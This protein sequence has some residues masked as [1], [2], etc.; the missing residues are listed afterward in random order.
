MYGNPD[1]TCEQMLCSSFSQG[2]RE[3]DLHKGTKL[4]IGRSGIH[5]QVL[6]P[7][8]S[9]LSTLCTAQLHFHG[10]PPLL[11][12]GAPRP[13]LAVLPQVVYHS[14]SG[15]TPVCSHRHLPKFKSL[16]K[17]RPAN[18]FQCFQIRN[19]LFGKVFKVWTAWPL[20]P[21][22]V[23]NGISVHQTGF[24]SFIISTLTHIRPPS[25]PLST[26]LTYSILSLISCQ[27][28]KQAFPH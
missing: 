9:A 22:Q 26:K 2:Y 27:F 16:F 25:A 28:L 6:W 15:L 7:S 1:K 18:V 4:V 24:P 13:P 21:L 17:V 19:K 5:T 10:Q 8:H 14:L 20:L 3:Y 23:W 11:Q 12:H